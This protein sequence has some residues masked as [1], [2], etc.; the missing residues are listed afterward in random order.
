V[1]ALAVGLFS[2]SAMAQTA[3]GQ[4]LQK[5]PAVPPVVL[6]KVT[7]DTV[8]AP[9]NL[10]DGLVVSEPGIVVP[11]GAPQTGSVSLKV[12]VSN[13]GAV[14]EVVVE[15]GDDAL[16]KV[17]ADGVMG[18]KYQPYMVNGEPREFQTSI[19]IRFV[20]G[21]GKRVAPP[22][23]IGMAGLG[24]GI[25]GSG[26]LTVSPG[27]VA[28]L[29]ERPVA[30]MYPPEAKAQHI[31][32]VV[33]MRAIISKDGTIEDLQVISGHPLLIGAAM[34]AVKQWKYRPYLLNGAPTAVQT[35]INVNFTFAPTKKPDA[36]TPPAAT[37]D[38]Q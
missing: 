2:V 20:D 25:A 15:Q 37:P 11:E 4:S 21:V 28:G 5:I 14:E 13:T 23:V 35:T 27:V 36:A 33:V 6:Q 18:W 30:P 9:L 8:M 17:A 10:L 34:N 3:L 16:R 24:G 12:L 32:G 29:M 19:L 38:P 22:L 1:A 26:A 7:A 31:Q